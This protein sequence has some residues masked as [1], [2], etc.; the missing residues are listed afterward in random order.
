LISDLQIN[1]PFGSADHNV[2]Q[3][4]VNLPNCF[5]DNTII[6]DSYY[7]DFANA[8][9]E[10]IEGYLANIN[11]AHEF[12]FVFNTEDYWKLFLMHV[13]DA[14]QFYVPVKKRVVT[15]PRNNK[16]FPRKIIKMLNHKARLWKR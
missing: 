16:K 15:N 3:F 12:S 8:D 9:Y 14:I 1:C 13:Y 5:N 2:V 4:S 7:Y 10:L 11:W 6:T